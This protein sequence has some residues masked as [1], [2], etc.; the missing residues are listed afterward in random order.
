M[1]T[2][3]GVLNEKINIRLLVLLFVAFFGL[4]GKTYAQQDAMFTQYMFNM[5]AINPAYAGNQGY[6]TVTALHRTQWVNI[7][8]APRTN[9]ISIDTPIPKKNIGLGLSVIH[10]KI[11]VTNTT[12]ASG[13]YSFQIPFDRGM[14]SFGLQAGFSFY[15][16][17]FQSVRH[18]QSPTAI[19]NSFAKNVSEFLPNFGAGVFYNTDKF[20]FGFSVPHLINNSLN[21]NKSLNNK[22]KARQYRHFFAMAGYVFA[23]REHIHL[24]P[25][26]LLKYV[27]GA[28]IEFDLNANVWFF[29]IIGL[30]ASYRTG[31]S[32]DLLGQVQINRRLRIGYSYDYSLT[33]LTRY[34]AGSHE[35]MLRYQFAFDKTRIVTPR[36]F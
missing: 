24:K 30:G 20:Y 35:I 33:R 21:F 26:V 4:V 22:E 13:Y 3:S 36:Y 34:N 6:T 2:I 32:F 7:E 19:D 28:P 10:D 25:Y 17:D 23:I 14:L 12:G 27:Q 1:K 29:D 9:T 15:R 11:G 8:G 16:A 18:N 31:D 5:I